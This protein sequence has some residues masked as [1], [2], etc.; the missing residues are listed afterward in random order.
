MATKTTMADTMKRL[1]D[2]V[3]KG[4]WE[5]PGPDGEEQL[6][7][8]SSLTLRQA[9]LA[10]LHYY[11]RLE[12][13]QKRIKPFAEALAKV[14]VD[15]PDDD[16]DDDEAPMGTH[17]PEEIAEAQRLIRGVVPKRGLSR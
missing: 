15:L 3:D 5:V 8:G 17:T 2:G 7:Y 13:I 11:A 6:I 4:I 16:D 12:R 9:K 14:T 1:L 10:M